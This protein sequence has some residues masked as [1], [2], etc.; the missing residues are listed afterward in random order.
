MYDPFTWRFNLRLRMDP[1]QEIVNG[2][3]VGDLLCVFTLGSPDRMSMGIY[4]AGNNSFSF[5]VY[6]LSG[7]PGEFKDLLLMN[8]ALIFF[9]L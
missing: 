1:L 8:P 4:Q 6:N 9:H 7:L 5:E 2:M 3:Q